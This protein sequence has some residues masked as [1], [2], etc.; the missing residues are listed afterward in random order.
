MLYGG[1]EPSYLAWANVH[2]FGGLTSFYVSTADAL[3]TGHPYGT[4]HYPPGYPLFLAV[5]K[6]IGL[7]EIDQIRK[8]QALLDAA[9]VVAVYAL[10]RDLALNKFWSLAAAVV[11]A[12]C[13]LWAAGSIWPLAESISIPLLLVILVLLG[14]AAANGTSWRPAVLGVIIG[15]SALVRPDLILLIV[16]ATLWLATAP[17]APARLPRAAA[18]LAG[19]ALVVGSWGLYNR[20]AH[21]VWVFGS[22]TGG[23]GLWEGLGELPNGYGYVLDDSAANHVLKAQGYEWSSIEGDQYFK[24]EYVKA[25]RD[26]P[27]YVAGVI[28]ARIPRVLFESEHLQPLFFG[29]ARQVLD[30]TGLLL[31]GLAAWIRRRHLFSL[32]VLALPPL[33][34]LGSIGLVHYEPRYVRYVPLSYMFGATIVA[35]ESWQRLN[36]RS[37]L[38]RAAAVGLLTCAGVYATRELL[39]LHAAVAQGAGGP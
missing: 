39:A 25:W 7:G 5:L 11:Y 14:S 35:A 20:T 17:A 31:A 33:Y 4:I 24:R 9:A 6:R 2:Y 30:A 8:V 19:F 29:R 26:H 12:V 10:A 15:A 23:L 21:G 38:V 18:L 16:P 1:H 36:R 28:A 22:T 34:A 13:P 32:L 3:A 37:P 27:V